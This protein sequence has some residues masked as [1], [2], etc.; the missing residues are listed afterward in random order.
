MSKVRLLIASS[1]QSLPVAQAIQENLDRENVAPV[2]WTQDVFGLS[3]FTLEAFIA[4]LDE[5]DF[6]VF[7][8]AADDLQVRGENR[9]SVVRDNVLFELGLCIGK[10]GRDRSFLVAPRDSE[11]FHLPS[12]LAGLT[13]ATYNSVGIPGD[14]GALGSACNQIMRCVKEVGS[15]RAPKIFP[16]NENYV[17]PDKFF[18]YYPRQKQDDTVRLLEEHIRDAPVPNVLYIAA[19][20]LQLLSPWL[21]RIFSGDHVQDDFDTKIEAICIKK[22]GQDL[23]GSLIALGLLSKDFYSA[24]DSNLRDLETQCAAVHKSVTVKNWDSFPFFHGTLYGDWLTYS[25]W[26]T[27]ENGWLSH[28]A[29]QHV[30]H[31]SYKPALFSKYE[32]VLV[33]GF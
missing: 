30:M 17:S 32:T 14:I 25:R 21:C 6:G 26:E 11:N 3:K 7:V 18:Y 23:A 4:R 31:R 28:F 8:F 27:D 33:E 20:K 1:T 19:A 24:L 10:L 15:R 29:T 16:P 5:F 2:V 9:Q 13:V 12:D 22:I